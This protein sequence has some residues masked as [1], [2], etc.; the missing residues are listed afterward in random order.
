MPKATPRDRP[1]QS[2]M[3]R[4]S[5]ILDSTRSRRDS[6]TAT[7][8]IMRI[9]ANDMRIWSPAMARSDSAA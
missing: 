3:V 8:A 7:Y 9:M 5:R 6:T 4:P 2:T 1:T